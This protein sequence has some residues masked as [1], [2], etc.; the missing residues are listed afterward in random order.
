MGPHVAVRELV[1]GL[2][3]R[4]LELLRVLV[5]ALRDRRVD[6]IHP[7]REVRRE[8][9]G[10]VRLRRVVGIRNGPLGGLVL[11]RPLP[12]AGRTL[13]ELP[14]VAEEVVEVVVG[15]LRRGA[16]PGP[17]QAAGDRVL[18]LA[19]AE[20]VLPA[21]TLLLEGSPLGLGPDV[22][23]RIGGAVALAQ[24]VTA[25]DQRDRLL[26]VHRHAG[27]RRPD[28]L[29]GGERVR[30]AV[31]S[32]RVDVDQA[33]LGGGER[34]LQLPVRRET[35]VAQ[36]LALRPPVDVALR[37]PDVLATAG[38]AERLEPHR[39][40]GHVAGE[41]HQVG[42]RDLA[43]VL[44]LD[45]PEQPARLVEVPVVGPAVEGREPDR[46]G[47]RAAAAV[48][49]AV[50]AGA[51][52]GQPDEQ[53]AVV[54]VVGRPPVLRRRQQ[55]RD[56]LLQGI[57]VELLELLGVVEV[58]PHRIGRGRVL[59]QDSQVELVRPPVP[60][61]H[62]SGRRV[63]VGRA[64][65][66]ALAGAPRLLPFGRF[67]TLG[68]PRQANGQDQAG[69]GQSYGPEGTHLAVRSHAASSSGP[70]RGRPSSAVR[71]CGFR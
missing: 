44:L 25:G 63:S 27:E 50:G 38:E 49:D 64:R 56:V 59:V 6:R 32:L 19:L 57:Q 41:D 40:E 16:R 47:G 55:L 3:E 23:A 17:F 15:P 48:G 62:G 18:A 10:G 52:P 21:E 67:L 71:S 37:L 14:L 20:S 53:A 11:G 54:A 39:L 28:V 9:H 4:G 31:G 33:H 22:L 34:A 65:H 35:L 12:R 61:R 66:R 13:R 58:L 42:P 51:V 36:P 68:R 45:R 26:V 8:H 2:G 24:R 69:Q 5:E 43:T 29:R 30:L 60:V 46:A 7:E 70:A 1:P